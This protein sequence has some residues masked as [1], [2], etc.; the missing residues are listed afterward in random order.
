MKKSFFFSAITFLTL[1]FSVN[2]HKANAQ[3]EDKVISELASDMC[4][5]VNNGLSGLSTQFS[6]MII[7]VAK[8]N[9]DFE[10]ALTDYMM[11]NP[12]NTEVLKKD[13]GI[14]VNFG[15]GKFDKCLNSFSAK[16]SN[17]NLFSNQEEYLKKLT[18]AI[19]SK[20]GCD[21]TYAFMLIGIQKEAKGK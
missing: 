9:L 6:E 3:S 1:L 19:G 14:L 20:D 5:C 12:G 17:V 11:M 13:I 21:L 8:N 7:K 15:E 2:H 18:E 10:K 16:Y 4:G